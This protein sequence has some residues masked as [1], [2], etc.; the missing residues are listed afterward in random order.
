MDS[1]SGESRVHTLTYAGEKIR[2]TYRTATAPSWMHIPDDGKLKVLFPIRGLLI[3][4][5]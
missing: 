5:R 1:V 2:G 4:V 3:S